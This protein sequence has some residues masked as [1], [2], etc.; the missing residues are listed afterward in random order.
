M[1]ALVQFRTL[2]TPAIAK[3]FFWVGFV[4][5]VMVA[6]SGLIAGLASKLGGVFILQSFLITAIGIPTV[7]VISELLIMA[8][9]ANENLNAIRLS[10]EAGAMP[11][12]SSPTSLGSGADD[13]EK[14][15]KHLEKMEAEKRSSNDPVIAQPYL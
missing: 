1:K 2:V 9:N 13:F 7:R 10:L 3:A 11:V 5:F 14:H 12:S 15:I 6:L 4:F 8:H